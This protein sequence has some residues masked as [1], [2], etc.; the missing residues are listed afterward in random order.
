MTNSA[1]KS[2]TLNPADKRMLHFIDVLEALALE[3]DKGKSALYESLNISLLPS[4]ITTARE[5]ISGL[6]EQF[7]KLSTDKENVVLKIE[8]SYSSQ[9][10]FL[11]VMLPR[12][13]IKHLDGLREQIYHQGVAPPS[14]ALKILDTLDVKKLPSIS[15]VTPVHLFLKDALNAEPYHTSDSKQE[16][17]IP[18]A[19]E[20]LDPM[21]KVL[22]I[23]KRTVSAELDVAITIGQAEARINGRKE[24]C[25]TIRG[26]ADLMAHV[27]KLEREIDPPEALRRDP[28]IASL[29]YQSQEISVADR[30]TLTKLY[31][32]EKTQ[33]VVLS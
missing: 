4:K 21:K 18:I 23:L 25:V 27:A 19:R 9:P 7:K 33:S 28:S 12:E 6:N 14:G 29:L 31:S 26:N 20:A 1:I 13:A 11:E 22:N 17:A 32:G 2:H 16:I 10:L 5:C 30:A 8:N 3:Q 24:T 15:P